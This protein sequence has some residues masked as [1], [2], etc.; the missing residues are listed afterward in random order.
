[1]TFFVLFRTLPLLAGVETGARCRLFGVFALERLEFQGLTVLD[2]T[3]G[4]LVDRTVAARIDVVNAAADF[5]IATD[6]NF[7][8]RIS[9]GVV[10]ARPFVLERFGA[11]DPRTTQTAFDDRAA[12]VLHATGRGHV[13]FIAFDATFV[14]DVVFRITIAVVQNVCRC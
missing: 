10:F 12:V 8:G 5:V 2:A 9:A 4:G 7:F 6:L 3:E 13:D 1:M 14:H 11:F